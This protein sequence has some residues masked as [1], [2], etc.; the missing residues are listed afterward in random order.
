MRPSTIA[1]VD[2]AAAANRQAHNLIHGMAAATGSTLHTVPGPITRSI[3][4]RL[5]QRGRTGQLT[6]CAHLSYD[7][8]ALAFWLAWAPG[9]LRCVD[10]ASAVAKRIRGTREDRRCDHC[11]RYTPKIHAASGHLPSV[12]VDLGG[13]T[14]AKAVPPITMLYGLCP[15]CQR[16]DAEGAA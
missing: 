16:F 11:K 6:L 5:Q 10:C 1:L 13:M 3:L 8:P 15:T 9:R 2:Q 7:A 14:P 4:G 12:V